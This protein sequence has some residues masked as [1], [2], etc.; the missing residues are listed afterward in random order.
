MEHLSSENE[1]VLRLFIIAAACI[2]A[3]LTTIFSL[4]HGIFEVYPFLYILPII[5]MVY[6]YP[7]RAVLFSLVISLLYIS[8]IYLLGFSNPAVIVISTA[9]FAIFI[10]IAVVASSYANRLLEERSRIKNIL[11]NSQDGIFCLDLRTKQIREINVKCAHWLRYDRKDL[12]GKDISLIW[13]DEKG[14]EQ[15]FTDAKKGLGNTEIEAVFVAH[16]RTLLRFVIS[17]VLVTYDRMLCSVIDITGSKI[18]DEEIR[19]TLEDLEE[20]VHQRTAHLEKMNEE[21][22]AEILERRRFE[23]TILSG[24]RVNDEE[25]EEK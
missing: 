9:W 19:K 22:R 5:L 21:L 11:D 17:A 13:T 3:I 16:D 25:E 7:E 23:S 12:I 4:T 1:E 24:D 18:V 15:F 6:F 20:Q 2:G 10:A 8:L 14:Q